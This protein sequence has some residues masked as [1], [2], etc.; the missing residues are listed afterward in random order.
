MFPSLVIQFPCQFCVTLL[1]LSAMF[2]IQRHISPVLWSVVGDLI[3]FTADG[4]LCSTERE[5]KLM[6]S[7]CSV[8]TNLLMTRAFV[9]MSL[10]PAILSKL[11]T[12]GMI[13]IVLWY[14]ARAHQ[15]WTGIQM[16]LTA[17]HWCN[18]G[19]LQC[20]VSLQPK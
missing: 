9:S 1:D 17:S 11:L 14:A 20:C 2:G 15:F 5:K 10:T 12:F 7:K 13:E 18:V 16:S 4:H 3:G 19:S 8:D 6:N